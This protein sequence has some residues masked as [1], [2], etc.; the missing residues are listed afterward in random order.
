MPIGPG[1]EYVGDSTLPALAYIETVEWLNALMVWSY[2]RICSKHFS[3]IHIA[4]RVCSQP[5]RQD[6]NFGNTMDCI[7]AMGQ[8]P[9]LDT[10]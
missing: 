2:P 9:Q 10:E 7:L 8:R 4:S 3:R 1:T 6:K 5:V